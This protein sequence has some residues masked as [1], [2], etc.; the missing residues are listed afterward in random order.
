[1]D[2][3]LRAQIVKTVQKSVTEALEGANERWVS[4][5]ELTTYFAFFTKSWLR[6]YGQTL[7]RTRA[8]VTADGREH[9]TGWCYPLHKIQRM[10]RDG[11]IKGL[12]TN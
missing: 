8:I 10:V 4:G 5:E 2:A 11:E 3:T 1:M 7:P 6:L 12:R 9:S